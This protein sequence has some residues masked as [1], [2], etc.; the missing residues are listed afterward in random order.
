MKE[1]YLGPY[2]ITKVL[3]G[4]YELADPSDKSKKTL[5]ATGAH[6][7]PY[8]APSPPHEEN[9]SGK[10]ISRGVLGDQRGGFHLSPHPED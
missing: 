7:K 3:H 2:T 6:L 1:H 4:T 5:R 9:V 8:I 10:A